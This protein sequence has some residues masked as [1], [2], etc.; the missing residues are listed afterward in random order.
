VSFAKALDISLEEL[1]EDDEGFLAELLRKLKGSD[2]S[3][4]SIPNI[5]PKSK[6]RQTNNE[7]YRIVVKYPDGTEI[8]I[9]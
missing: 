2:S 3:R 6:N 5:H 4:K 8:K 9:R 7:Q 1:T